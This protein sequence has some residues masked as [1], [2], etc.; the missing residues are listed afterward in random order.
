MSS[1]LLWLTVVV[2]GFGALSLRPAAAVSIPGQAEEQD[3]EAEAER[4][5]W[6]RWSRHDPS[7]KASV[8]YSA[9]TRFVRDFSDNSP[10][11]ALDYLY[12]SRR[13]MGFLNHLV[14]QLQQVPV[15]R[16]ARDEQLAY[17]I[18][19][20]NAEA[21]RI[22]ALRFPYKDDSTR[23]LVLGE[24]WRADTLSVEDMPISLEDIE[25]RIL[26]RQWPDPR[27]I[28]GLYLPASG[29]PVLSAVPITGA[30]V[31]NQLEQRARTYI[32]AGPALELVRGELHVSALYYWD[33]ALFADDL[34][35]IQHL[36][37]YADPG[38]VQQLAGISSVRA[39]WLNWRLNTFNSGYDTNADRSGGGG[40]S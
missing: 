22:T 1:R 30:E 17:W 6:Q 7:S 34:A 35:L 25:R 38:L 3:L 4:G 28:Y 29:A 9:W 18:N 2:L 23:E 32:N 31:W 14:S 19:L 15:S 5:D 27:V 16:L 33:K 40:S 20:H 24:H 39:S 8:D 37:R 21:V 11:G 10:R 36:R 26:F 12:I 13:G